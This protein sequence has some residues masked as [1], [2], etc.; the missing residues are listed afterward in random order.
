[1]QRVPVVSC[2]HADL[3]CHEMA[4]LL[5]NTLGIEARSGFHCAAMIHRYLGTEHGGTL[6]M[7]LGHTSTDA[8]VDAAIEGIKLLGSC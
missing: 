3:S 8:D 5:D 2:T 4:I 7:S 6:R 1:M